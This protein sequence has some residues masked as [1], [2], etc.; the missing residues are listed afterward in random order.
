[1]SSLAPS[2]SP[3][4]PLISSIRVV[5]G[6]LGMKPDWVALTKRW[7]GGGRWREEVEK[8]SRDNSR[9][10]FCGGKQ[11]NALKAGRQVRN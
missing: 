10:F 2:A 5:G 3:R 6:V 8:E 7:G 11:R 4:R 1:M 9:E